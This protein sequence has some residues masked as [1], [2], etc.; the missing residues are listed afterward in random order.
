MFAVGRYGDKR[1]KQY[2][3]TVTE[4][5]LGGN[6]LARR[7]PDQI[8][9]QKEEFKE[10]MAGLFRYVQTED[11]SIPVTEYSREE[12]HEVVNIKKAITS[13]FQAN[14]EGT[15]MKEEADP[16]SLHLAKYT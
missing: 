15:A 13:A 10:R 16:Q 5:N 3:L 8:D 1:A 6:I 9:R 12:D 7:E 4:V 14:F 11:G 2:D